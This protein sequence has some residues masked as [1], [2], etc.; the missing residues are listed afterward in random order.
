MFRLGDALDETG[1]LGREKPLG[2]DQKQD[3]GDDQ[4]GDGDDQGGHLAIEHPH[5]RTIVVGDDAV[6]DLL[7]APAKLAVLD[8][9]VALE[10]SGRERRHQGQGDHRR[11]D[12][13]H[14][15]GDGE[16]PEEPS[17]H[18]AHE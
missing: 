17:D 6:G 8:L 3:D 4:G 12:D 9:V 13:G 2:N 15:Q 10:P 7:G 14:R 16:F 18:V 11:D 5:Q 1:V